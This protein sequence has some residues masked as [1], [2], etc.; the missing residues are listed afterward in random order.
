MYF[1]HFTTVRWLTDTV[2]ERSTTASVAAQLSRSFLISSI[3]PDDTPLTAVP[4]DCRYRA[5]ISD[6]VAEIKV[7][8]YA[9]DKISG[10]SRIVLRGFIFLPKN[11]MIF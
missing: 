3:L 9:Y 11:L 6:P 1:S 7:R 8:A 10:G 5:N 4:A 2:D